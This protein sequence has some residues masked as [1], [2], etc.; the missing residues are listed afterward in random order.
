VNESFKLRDDRSSHT[1]AFNDS[2]ERLL[3]AKKNYLKKLQNKT[4]SSYR[5]RML[6]TVYRACMNEEASKKEELTLVKEGVERMSGVTD[7]DNFLI[8]LAQNVTTKEYSFFDID[9]IAN[10]E[11]PN[12]DD[13]YFLAEVMSL[14][15]RSYYDKKEAVHDLEVLIT[16]FFK[17]IGYDKAEDRAK[18]VLS[19]E[20]NFAQTYPLPSEFREK[21]SVKTELPRSDFQEKYPHFHAEYWLKRIPRT[22]LIRN[23]APENFAALNQALE[24]TPLDTLKDVYLFHALS[25]YMDDAY[26]EFYKKKFEF[27]QK[28]LGGPVVRPDREERCTKMVMGRYGKE[29]DEQMLPIL[30]PHFPEKKFVRL[31]EKIRRSILNG[32]E[33]NVWLSPAAKKKA[34]KK[35]KMARLDLV[36]PRRE[37]DWDFTPHVKY[38]SNTPYENMRNLSLALQN[39]M[40]RELSKPRNRNRWS[41]GPLTVNAY[42]SPPDNKFVM[43][44]GI[45]QYPFYDPKL[46]DEQNFAAVGM[47][48]AHE[49]GH[50]IDDKGS[51]YDEKGQLN[52]WMSDEDLKR[53]KTRGARLIE[54]FN[55]S[56]H[57]GELT[58]GENIADLVGLTFAYQAAFPKN[59]GSIQSKKD[60]FAQYARLWCQVQR[61]KYREMLLKTDPHAMGDARVNE[62]VKHQ[63]GFREAYSCSYDFEPL[64]VW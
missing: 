6:A 18:A 3:E 52:A 46:S 23:L 55:E 30:F 12:K 58:Q 8:M 2:Y 16:D 42:Y 49:L 4:P 62:Q 25:D 35:I 50:A 20:K 10:L 13:L 47:V 1:F 29:L 37:K 32:L 5:G 53:F 27:N 21:I 19:F 15:E 44:I 38:S 61:P 39:K 28:H 34:I 63:P 41:M 36:K 9:S 57:N 22:T 24:T 60:F 43:P 33:Q 56:G 59:K 11:N 54:Q 14:P 64:Q 48:I 7:R 31:A 45:L 17:K 40:I 51:R 26:P